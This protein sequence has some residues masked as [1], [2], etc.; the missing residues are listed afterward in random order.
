MRRA[1][2]RRP[3]SPSASSC[4]QQ[5][6][7]DAGAAALA[8]LPFSFSL[9]PHILPSTV[10]PGWDMSGFSLGRK[11]R[12]KK[13][14]DGGSPGWYLTL[15]APWWRQAQPSSCHWPQHC[16][17][18]HLGGEL[19][20][21]APVE[22]FPRGPAGVYWHIFYL[23]QWLE[24]LLRRGTVCVGVMLLKTQGTSA[25]SSTSRD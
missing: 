3:P 11:R 5:V 7:G 17:H 20:T 15:S 14:H 6:A 8:S 22:L 24:H 25:R 9:G 10:H 1:R 13:R 4:P 19:L 12:G 16:C 21:P 23:A 2:S 18:Q